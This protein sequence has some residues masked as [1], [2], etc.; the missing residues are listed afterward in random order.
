M[1]LSALASDPSPAYAAGAAT[2]L[3]GVT[4]AALGSTY[5]TACDGGPFSLRRELNGFARSL[6]YD[7]SGLGDVLAPLRRIAFPPSG[8]VADSRDGAE[9]DPTPPAELRFLPPASLSVP[10]AVTASPLGPPHPP[11]PPTPTP[12]VRSRSYA[13]DEISAATKSSRPSAR[14]SPTPRS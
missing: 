5:A 14:S 2:L 12:Q 7:R 11:T 3:S 13:T 1:P 9:I 6:V 10:K 8:A 4:A